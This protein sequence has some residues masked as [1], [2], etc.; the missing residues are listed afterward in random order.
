M[1]CAAFQWDQS[2]LLTGDDV[3]EQQYARSTSPLPLLGEH[4]GDVHPPLTPSSVI[5]HLLT[6]GKIGIIPCGIGVHIHIL[7]TGERF[8]ASRL[9]TEQHCAIREI[10]P[11]PANKPIARVDS[12]C[13]GSPTISRLSLCGV[14]TPAA[15]RL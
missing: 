10:A 15:C 11:P 4:R 13:P 9:L 6:E 14:T 12:P 7:A 1:R 3:G 8:N 2:S 5:Q